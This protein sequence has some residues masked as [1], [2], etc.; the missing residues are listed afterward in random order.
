MQHFSDLLGRALKK[1]G[2]EKR[3]KAEKILFS[4]SNLVGK[5]VAARSEP[6]NLAHGVL[7]VRVTN[8][9]W[10]HHLMTLKE[11][12]ITQIN[13]FFGE[14]VIY[15]IKFQAGYLKK[16]QNYSEVDE[17]KLTIKPETIVL[18]KDDIGVADDIAQCITDGELRQKVKKILCKEM[19]LR[20]IRQKSNWKKC[21]QCGTLCP[22]DQ[23]Y[24]VACDIQQRDLL[25]IEV[26]NLLKQAPWLSYKE[27]TSYIQCRKTDFMTIKSE[28]VD[29]VRKDVASN[30]ADSMKIAM[31]AMLIYGV[32][33]EAI[34]KNIIDGTLD[35]IRGKKNVFTPRC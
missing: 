11:Q 20:K 31:A 30:Q 10:V 27:C 25:K 35:K 34:T 13:D 9:V 17:E 22:Q 33:P 19:A 4:W 29:K 7:M 14:K 3:Y 6:E 21:I 16:Y 15:D 26:R 5:E 2:L 12:I 8:S 1:M 28:L 23:D 24:C 18:S 32:K